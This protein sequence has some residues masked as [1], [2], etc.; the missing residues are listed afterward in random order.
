MTPIKCNCIII[1]DEPDAIELLS[2]SIKE[3]Y[4]NIEILGTF[5][6]WKQALDF[7]RSNAVD[8]IFLDI[9][10]PQKSGFDL[11]TLVPDL[12]S[13]IILVTAYA[14]YALDAF[15]CGVA[16]YVLK[17]IDE[18][19]FIKTVDRALER[20]SQKQAVNEARQLKQGN[21]LSKIAIPNFKGN[22]YVNADDVIYFEA[23]KRHT[24]VVEK[25]RVILS[26]YNI[27]KFTSLIPGDI[28]LQVHRSF[29]VNIRHIN[30]YDAVGLLT[31]SN[32]DTIPVSKNMKD[33]FLNLLSKSTFESNDM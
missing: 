11:L 18:Q 19:L 14:E 22:D 26:S 7:I 17:P 6:H 15:K 27:G 5:L 8:I 30:R 31:M 9:S 4:S 24:R 29:V 21:L 1:D 32:G 2:D 23:L 16:G 33:T 3:L 12:K 10:M 20:V 25:Q 13:E 28:F